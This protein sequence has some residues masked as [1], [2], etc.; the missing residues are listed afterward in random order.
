MENLIVLFLLIL[1]AFQGSILYM[2][3]KTAYFCKSIYNEV[4]KTKDDVEITKQR[5]ETIMMDSGI[6]A[7]N[8]TDV[9]ADVHDLRE[10]AKDKFERKQ[11][12]LQSKKKKEKGESEWTTPYSKRSRKK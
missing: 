12:K 4:R 3:Y 11:E 8:L 6:I 1:I 5:V 7:D 10:Y 9:K 2:I